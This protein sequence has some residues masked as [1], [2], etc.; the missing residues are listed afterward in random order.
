MPLHHVEEVARRV[1][2]QR[3]AAEVRIGRQE[4]LR[5]AVQ[6]GEVAAPAA[7]NQDLLAGLARMVQHHHAPPAPAG[8]DCAHQAGG[9]RAEDD[10]IGGVHDSTC[11]AAARRLVKGS[12]SR[13]GTSE[14]ANLANRLAKVA[15]GEPTQPK[16]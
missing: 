6:I 12:E 4:P 10:D 11:V 5:R 13:T 15:R 14:V 9:A 8:G 3:G 2:C 16:D 7:G 1:A